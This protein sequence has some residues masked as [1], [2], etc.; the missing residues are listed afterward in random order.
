MIAM[1]CLLPSLLLQSATCSPSWIPTFGGE[2][3]LEGRAL[4]FEVFDDGTGPALVVA[5]GFTSVAGMQLTNMAKWDAS[6]WSPFGPTPDGMVEALCLFDDGTG[7]AL[8][9]AGSFSNAGGLPA[10][11]VARW[12]GS[13]WSPLG[14]GMNGPVRALLAFDD[15][16]GPALYA[17]GSFTVAGGLPAERVARWDGSSWAPLGAGLGSTTL[18][19]KHVHALS[20]YDDGSGMALYAGGRMT[21]S[22]TTP[23]SI[24]SRWD[25]ASWQSV[26]NQFAQG[27]AS[28]DSVVTMTVYDDGTGP[29][30]YVGGDFSTQSLPHIRDLAKWD[31]ASWTAPGNGV[32]GWNVTELTVFDDGAGP[33]LYVGGD[34][35]SVGGIPMPDLA[36]WDGS[37]W[38]TLG[39]GSP[40]VGSFNSWAFGQFDDGSGPALFVSSG[41]LAAGGLPAKYIAKLQNSAWIPMGSG[42]FEPVMGT[43]VID[44]GQG[45]QLI[46]SFH[47]GSSQQV[48]YARWTGSAWAAMGPVF[49]GWFTDF[50]TFDA[51][52]GPTLLAHAASGRL[53]RW[54]G[55]NWN[56]IGGNW[57]GQIQS[58]AQFDDGTGPRLYAGG[59]FTTNDGAP[60]DY[61]VFWDGSTWSSFGPALDGAV[62]CVAVIDLG[63]GPQLFMS[64]VLPAGSQPSNVVAR[65]NGSGWDS[66]GAGLDSPGPFHAGA[67]TMTAYDDGSGAA[68]VVAGNFAMAGSTPVANIAKWDG[69]Q[70][71]ALGAGVDGTIERVL[72]HND[73]N[74]PALFAVGG[75]THAGGS[76]A[77]HLARWDGTSWSSLGFPSDSLTSISVLDQGD[78]HGPSLV[79][80]GKFATSPANDSHLARWGGCSPSPGIA[81]CLGDG[82]ATP[83]PCGN[84]APAGHQ[85]GCLHSLG[86][87]G[88]L[89]STGTPSIAHDSLVLAGSQMPNSA[90][91]YF[92]GTTRL[93]G[94]AGTVFGDGLRCA[95]G[96]LTRLAT[97]SNAGGASHYPQGMEAS[98]SVRGA[99][100]PGSVR[101]Y[102]A[103]YRNAAAF[104]V[105]ATH[106]LTNGI[107]T[108]WL[109]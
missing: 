51:G 83:C 39:V 70:W 24:V 90:C 25:G 45:P 41:F 91:L 67:R 6:G 17:G 26:G 16:T 3:G 23:I 82:S 59:W 104:C 57:T 48:R 77:A 36:R 32:F 37:A 94:G 108:A 89:S 50:G 92:Q 100:P 76:P 68:L 8:Y 52:T 88:R 109:P 33:K 11:R 28:F 19:N 75:F 98:I 71:H 27:G 74:G 31:G 101:T 30:L 66:L 53:S 34:F 22:G 12:D 15:G 79:V 86:L 10:A 43:T 9:A 107:E 85:G 64:R 58:L 97:K 102:Q 40:Q 5:G 38:S 54:D 42:E 72:A 99:V 63:T 93:N 69:V 44:D 2:P 60:G 96:T 103:W 80:A 56:Q 47:V 7:T 106:N 78:G 14:S 81:F 21:H 4:A 61:L 29:A 49:S 13:A 1:V 20:A 105:P 55:S 62:T 65:W 18:G 35:T 87:S 84:S 73:G 46:A 95:G